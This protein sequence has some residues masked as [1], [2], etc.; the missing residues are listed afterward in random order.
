MNYYVIRMELQ[1]KME[2]DLPNE[3]SSRLSLMYKEELGEMSNAYL[4]L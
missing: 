2:G 1:K 3:G 4:V